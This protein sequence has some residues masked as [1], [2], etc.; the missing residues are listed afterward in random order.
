MRDWT[1]TGR[2]GAGHHTLAERERARR[3]A[4]LAEPKIRA[5]AES[6]L[7]GAASVCC[8]LAREI[9]IHWAAVGT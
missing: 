7:G 6:A 4:L 8:T 9:G 5:A 2:A 3:E 1:P